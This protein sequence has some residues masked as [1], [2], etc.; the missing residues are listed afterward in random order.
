MLRERPKRPTARYN[1]LYKKRNNLMEVVAKV[2]IFSK[3]NKRKRKGNNK[4]IISDI[5]NETFFLYK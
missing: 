2:E 5:I 1:I 3:E 4:I